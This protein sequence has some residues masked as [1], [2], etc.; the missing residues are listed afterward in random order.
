MKPP[1]RFFWLLVH[2]CFPRAC[3]L[4][5]ALLAAA[6]TAQSP[7][8]LRE[9][10]GLSDA[11]Q[12]LACYDKFAGRSAMVELPPSP[13]LRPIDAAA[14]P[15]SAAADG[16]GAAPP[17]A[18]PHGSDSWLSRYWE[19]DEQDKRGTFNYT[20]YRPNFFLPL[21]LAS[22]INGRPYSPTLGYA[23][24]LPHYQ[25]VETKLQLSL[26]TK[27]AQDLLLPGGD[28]WVGYTQESLWQLY[29]RGQ[30]TPFRNSDYQPEIFYML[31]V[32]Q[33]WQPLPGGWE[34]KLVQLGFVHQSNGQADP[35]SRSWN[36]LY[37][38]VGLERGDL[39]VLWRNE[40]RTDRERNAD[41]NNPDIVDYL[42]SNQWQVNWTPGRSAASVT[43]RP[44]LRGRGSV[45]LDW[46][47]PVFAAR[48]DGLRWYAQ[49]FSGYGDSLID[50]NLRQ[51][52]LGLG[53]TIFKF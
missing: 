26:R 35:L 37:A 18:D 6:A 17:A 50:Y 16:S 53:L 42:G 8:E 36:R 23:D 44:S 4:G 12:R 32:P 38:S 41:N 11:T 24:G 2:R 46:S 49:L 33:R 25:R 30:S 20:A 7:A 5:W 13:A 1:A 45:R 40:L 28:L 27:I 10:S 9:C 51:T 39:S 43:W 34:W 48:A 3:G 19:L 22:H 15:A 21:R 14:T 31:P 52:S 29:N 47:Y